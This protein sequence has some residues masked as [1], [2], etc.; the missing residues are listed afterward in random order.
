MS[1]RLVISLSPEA[2]E[3]MGKTVSGQGG[4]QDLLRKMQR[5]MTGNELTVYS[6]DLERL[7]RYIRAYG[8]GGWQDRLAEVVEDLRR[9][10][11]S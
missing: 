10:L 8:Q 1:Y 5:Q 9:H 7:V 4:F 6:E 2:A 3:A 11:V